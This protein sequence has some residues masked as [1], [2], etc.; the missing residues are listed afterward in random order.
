MIRRALRP[1]RPRTH[2]VVG[3]GS[4]AQ[5]VAVVGRGGVLNRA[6]A[7]LEAEMASLGIP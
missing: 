2:A 6:T 3:C 5:P 1:G 7:F 4:G